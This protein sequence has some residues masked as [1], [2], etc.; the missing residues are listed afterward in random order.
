[1]QTT[2]APA[3]SSLSG[4]SC[5]T[6]RNCTAVGTQGASQTTAL[7]EHWNGR[8][9]HIAQAPAPRG[10]QLAGVSCTSAKNC[11]AVGRRGRL[12]VLVER[13][14]HGAW[15]VQRA[16]SPVESAFN[17]VTCTS[18]K[19][20]FAVGF[21]GGSGEVLVDCV[22]VGSLFVHRHYRALAEVWNGS[23]WT[24]QHPRGLDLGSVSCSGAQACTAVGSATNGHPIIDRY[25]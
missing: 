10:S 18:R 20:C 1:V 25:S 13:L 15:H 7:V 17:G 2:P 8:T 3:A 19:N 16:P 11:V 12:K 23:R 21:K 4:V 5:V 9:W 14:S 24:I 6:I 22:A